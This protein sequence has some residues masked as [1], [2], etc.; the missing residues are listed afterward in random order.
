M[1]ESGGPTTD[2]TATLEA[3]ADT[4]IPGEKRHPTDH[5]VAGVTTGGGAV[6]AG[7]VALLEGPEGGLAPMLDQ[8][9]EVLNGHATAY[10]Q[11]HDL[12]SDEAVPPFVGLAFADRTALVQRLTAPD[13]PEREL[14]NGVAIFS[15]MAFDSAAHLHTADALAAGHVGLALLGFAAPDADGLWRFP[16]HTYGRPTAN[17][18]PDTAPT[19]S[20]A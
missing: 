10:A 5:A 11:E 9:V 12:E 17:L 13:N 2:R 18:H 7:A 15:Y 19:G 14:W 20:L 8:L 16:E 3:F 4:I 1:N 6:A